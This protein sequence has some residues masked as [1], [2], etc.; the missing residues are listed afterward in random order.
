MR[1]RLGATGGPGRTVAR[2]VVE[3]RREDRADIKLSREV[4]NVDGRG[5]LM[6]RV[7]VAIRAE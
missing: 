1:E 6:T 2:E 4:D 5:D 7:V 3:G